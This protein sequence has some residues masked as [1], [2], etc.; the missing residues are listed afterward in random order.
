MN[1]ATKTEQELKHCLKE[2][3]FWHVRNSFLESSTNICL[4]CKSCIYSCSS[5]SNR[6]TFVSLVALLQK[7]LQKYIHIVVHD[8]N[9]DLT[10]RINTLSYC[11]EMI[12]QLQDISFR[13][14]DENLKEKVSF[15]ELIGLLLKKTNIL[16]FVSYVNLLSKQIN[17]SHS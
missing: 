14:V 9:C 16:F 15:D 4:A 6:Q 1:Y 3:G 2:F 17:I 5:L 7:Y 10:I 11:I 12:Q 8:C 13:L